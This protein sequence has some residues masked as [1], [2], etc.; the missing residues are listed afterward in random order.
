MGARRVRVLLVAVAYAIST[1][2]AAV[3]SARA[4]AGDLRPLAYYKAI[5]DRELQE[6]QK[7]LDNLAYNGSCYN[8][9]YCLQWPLRAM[10]HM[11]QAT[12]DR[13]YFEQALEWSLAAIA[14]A[15]IRDEDG[16]KHW[17]GP[18]D[19][20]GA[21]NIAYFLFAISASTE[22]A[23]L[24]SIIADD[25]ELAR[26]FMADA[27]ILHAHIAKNVVERYWERI[28]GWKNRSCD[29]NR[30][31]MSTKPMMAAQTL[32]HLNAFRA[33]AAYAAMAKGIADC[34]LARTSSFKNGSII[35]DLER[36]DSPYTDTAHA[37]RAP[38]MVLALYEAGFA[39]DK[40][41]VDGIGRL[42]TRVIWNGSVANPLFHNFIDGTN[43]VPHNSR[44]DGLGPFRHGMIFS[45]FAWLSTHSCE[46][47]RA[48]QALL[49]AVEAGN[50]NASALMNASQRAGYGHLAL[51]ANVARATAW[52]CACRS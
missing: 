21:Q 5:F 24:V 26:E 38:G 7:A 20:F 43:K 14:G 30:G 37:N 6:H 51:I 9:Y 48:V 41:L 16:Y 42:F 45:G 4:G 49:D 13:K 44:P 32:V 33:N 52:G 31:A 28:R 11:Y 46:A 50:M 34:F 36:I 19:Y 12:G 2:L 10:I 35:W 27:R 22:I 39:F 47:A 1:L 8:G 23:R 29:K 17:A 3:P 25:Q 40:S 15:R 18:W